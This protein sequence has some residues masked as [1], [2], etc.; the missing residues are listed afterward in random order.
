MSKK[1]I[2][3]IIIAIVVIAFGSIRYYNYNYVETVT[4]YARITYTPPHKQWIN[5]AVG[6][7]EPKT[8]IEY[9]G[10]YTSDSAAISFE[11]DHRTRSYNR[12]LNEL[13]KISKQ[14]P[15][16][17]IAKFVR[18]TQIYTLTGLLNVQSIVVSVTHTRNFDQSK[19]NELV[20]IW[21]DPT[22]VEEFNNKYKLSVKLYP[23]E[24]DIL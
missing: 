14:T 9:L 16:D 22:K 7:T 11:Q 2:I 1:I 10:D 5:G 4:D 18:E 13:D 6:Y 19:I 24:P 15:K 3:P 8:E 21:N 12:T 23:V 17:D 20:K